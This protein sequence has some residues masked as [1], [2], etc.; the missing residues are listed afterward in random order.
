[1][2]GNATPPDLDSFAG[3][4]SED[5]MAPRS[6]YGA[7]KLAAHRTAAVYRD[8]YNMY[9]SCGILFNH[10][11]PIRPR[12]FV[13]RKITRQI[14]EMVL[15]RRKV[16][17][18]GNME[19]RRD[20]GFAGDYVEAMHKMLQVPAPVDCVVGTGLTFSISHFV[21]E[22]LMQYYIL[23]NNPSWSDAF[24]ARQR[25]DWRTKAS[26]MLEAPNDYIVS[27]DKYK[28]PAEVDYLRA[29]PTE[30]IHKLEWRAQTNLADLVTM[31]VKEDFHQLVRE[32][33]QEAS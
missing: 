33:E 1:M 23:L 26:A 12:E 9:I 2:F 32:Q 24:S 14:G 6:P 30:A 5:R 25:L 10:E 13:T 15:G 20:W 18:L 17:R 28:R 3:F 31:M 19:A 27:D 22:T 11:S 8:S 21:A 4:S 7:S 29:D 16:M